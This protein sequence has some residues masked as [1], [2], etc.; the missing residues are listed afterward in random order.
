MVA[1]KE[2]SWMEAGQGIRCKFVVLAFGNIWSYSRWKHLL[3]RVQEPKLEHSQHLLWEA[4]WKLKN[5]QSMPAT[6]VRGDAPKTTA[7]LFAVMPLGFSFYMLVENYTFCRLFFGVAENHAICM[8]YI[9]SI[10]FKAEGP[11]VNLFPL[12]RFR[13]YLWPEWRGE[14]REIVFF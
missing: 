7:C 10:V 12:L 8:F 5:S 1:G 9:D 13:T 14:R 4:A 6:E 11:L 3:S 2:Q